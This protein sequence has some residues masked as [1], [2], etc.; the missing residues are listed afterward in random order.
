MLFLRRNLE[1]ALTLPQPSALLADLIFIVIQRG[2][3]MQPVAAAIAEYDLK[4][5]LV[6][7]REWIKLELDRPADHMPL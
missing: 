4:S 6:A 1:L 5:L 3:D 2:D 7:Q